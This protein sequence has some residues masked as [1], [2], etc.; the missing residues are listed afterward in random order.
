MSNVVPKRG[1]LVK[2]I[3]FITIFVAMMLALVLGVSA[4]QIYYNDAYHNLV[5]I[6]NEKKGYF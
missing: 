6:T 3:L 4:E 1:E 2:K 5:K